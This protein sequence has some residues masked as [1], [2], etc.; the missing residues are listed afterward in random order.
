VTGRQNREHVFDKIVP[1]ARYRFIVT[2]VGNGDPTSQQD[3]L[4]LNELKYSEAPPFVVSFLCTLEQRV[5]DLVYKLYGVT[6]LEDA[7]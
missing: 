4:A 1:A 3:K 7:P 2:E 6:N 5:A